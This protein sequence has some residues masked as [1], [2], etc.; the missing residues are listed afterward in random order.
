MKTLMR[1][2]TGMSRLAT[3]IATVADYADLDLDGS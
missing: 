1:P 3:V 2:A